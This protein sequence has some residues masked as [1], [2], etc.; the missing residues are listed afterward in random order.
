MRPK[1]AIG[2]VAGVLLALLLVY[3]PRPASA[4]TVGE[5]L[6][7][8]DRFDQKPVALIGMAENVR[9]RAARRGNEYTT[10]KL[11]D[12]TGRINVF[13]WGKP[14][15]QTGDRVE[16]RGVFQKVKRVGRYTFRNEIEASSVKRTR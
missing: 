13:L 4:L 14:D 5:I 1:A 16:V 8:P 6:S 3:I 10:L 7:N 15:V 2:A 12:G 11:A 9:P